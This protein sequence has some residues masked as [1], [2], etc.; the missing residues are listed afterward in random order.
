MH[1]C[2]FV[3]VY[4]FE[5]VFLLWNATDPVKNG[6]SRLMKLLDTEVNA[7]IKVNLRHAASVSLCSRAAAT[8]RSSSWRTS[9]RCSASRET[10]RVWIPAAS[11]QLTQTQ[12]IKIF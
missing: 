7:P 2:T 5:R 6:S 4:F 12:V 11:V 8:R 3:L 10:R 1:L 9:E